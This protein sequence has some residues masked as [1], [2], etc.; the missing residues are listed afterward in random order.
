MIPSRDGDITRVEAFSD[1][2]IAFA[3]TLL[4]VS[5][6]TPR[7][8]DGLV[9]SLYGFIPFGLSFAALFL[10]WI[11]HTSLFRRYPLN[12][13]LSLVLN[14][15]LLFT[16]LFY[17]HPLKFLAASFAALISPTRASVSIGTVGNLRGLFML[18]A[19]GWMVVFALFALLYRRA[20]Q[21][22]ESL[23][24]KPVESYDAITWS[25]HYLGFVLSGVLSFIVAY[26]GLV[27]RWGL[28]GLAYASIGIFTSWNARSR[29]TGRD[30]LAVQV[31]EHPQLAYTGAIRTE[32]IQ[33]LI[34]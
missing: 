10:I 2:M 8:Y 29:K 26:L 33:H 19:V 14:G 4:V 9:D 23:G 6:E 12:D 34:K 21:N 27:I 17:V 20:W 16:V 3:A 13:R 15:A 28:P 31:A 30:A 5:L 18:Y 24:L 1:A 32:D 25:R 22:R 7:T 11:V